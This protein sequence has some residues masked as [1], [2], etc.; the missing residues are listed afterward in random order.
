M[1]GLASVATCSQCGRTVILFGVNKAKWLDKEGWKGNGYETCPKC[2]F[3]NPDKNYWVK[4]D[5]DE[6][7]TS[8]HD[9]FTVQN[10]QSMCVRRKR[11]KIG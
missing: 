3:R 4:R 5:I 1:T 10:W 8:H 6:C 9:S 7:S 2:K 11:K